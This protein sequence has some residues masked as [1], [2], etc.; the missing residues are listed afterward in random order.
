MWRDSIIL[1]TAAGKE[2]K[3]HTFAPQAARELK[4]ALVYQNDTGSESL[5]VPAYPHPHPSQLTSFTT[6]P[7]TI[8]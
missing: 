4:A 7:P 2:A 1:Q 3:M 5:A 6:L 8:S